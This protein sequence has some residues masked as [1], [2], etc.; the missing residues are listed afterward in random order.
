MKIPLQAAPHPLERPERIA[1]PLRPLTPSSL[2]EVAVALYVE[3]GGSVSFVSVRGMT[4]TVEL[5]DKGWLLCGVRAVMA[6]GT[7]ATG[8]HAVVTG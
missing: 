5:A 4:R 6:T 3:T 8:L 7:T 1:C 2:L